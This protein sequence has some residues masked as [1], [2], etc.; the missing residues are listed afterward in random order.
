MLKIISAFRECLSWTSED[1][2]D[3]PPRRTMRAERRRVGD[4]VPEPEGQPRAPCGL[5]RCENKARL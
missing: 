1:A 4:Q 2:P 3:G 5:L